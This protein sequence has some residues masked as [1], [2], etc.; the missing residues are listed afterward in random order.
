MKERFSEVARRFRRGLEQKASH[1]DL[2]P[3]CPFGAVLE[4]RV[5]DLEQ[6]FGELRGRVYGLIF[7]VLGSVILEVVMRLVTWPR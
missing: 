2:T 5:H 3:G 6:D 1:P 7:L 4:Q